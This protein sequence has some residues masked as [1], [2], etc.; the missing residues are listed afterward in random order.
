MPRDLSPEEAL[1]I[2]HAMERLNKGETVYASWMSEHGLEWPISSFYRLIR[3]GDAIVYHRNDEQLGPDSTSFE[4]SRETFAMDEAQLR[5]K[6][7]NHSGLR[8][9]LGL[10]KSW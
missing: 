6:A 7:T 2:D 9:V 1:A 5:E 3:E 10:E 4:I 8:Y